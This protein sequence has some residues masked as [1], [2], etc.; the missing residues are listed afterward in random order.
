MSYYKEEK[1]I[2]S[3]EVQSNDNREATKVQMDLPLD[4]DIKEF[5]RMCRR[6]AYSIGYTDQS[7]KNTFG[8][9][10]SEDEFIEKTKFLLNG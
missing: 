4:L 5:K 7:I 10:E 3:Y 1:C 9:D 2:L 6:L 8:Q